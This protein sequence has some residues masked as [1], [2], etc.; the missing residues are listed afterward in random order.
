MLF[1]SIYTWLAQRLHRVER[2][3]GVKLSWGNLAEQFGSEYAD[4]R[5]FKRKFRVALREALAV[6]ADAR[7]ELVPGGLVLKPSP[8]PV[9]RSLVALPKGDR[10]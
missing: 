7:V 5:N 6:Y 9:R 1:R 8:P 4:R 3:P 10:A 2:A